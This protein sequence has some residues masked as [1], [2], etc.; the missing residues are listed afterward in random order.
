MP[1]CIWSGRP[2]GPFSLLVWR[3]HT[4]CGTTKASDSPVRQWVLSGFVFTHHDTAAAL[5]EL[6]KILTMGRNS[7]LGTHTGWING[8]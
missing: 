5:A 8:L 3:F 7:A 4:D 1:I 6:K 2:I